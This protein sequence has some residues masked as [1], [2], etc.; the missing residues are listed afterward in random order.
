MKRLRI[1]L[2]EYKF[3][4]YTNPLFWVFVFIILIFS[5]VYTIIK[6]I[7][8]KIGF[9]DWWFVWFKLKTANEKAKQIILENYERRKKKKMPYFKRKAW[10]KAVKFIEDEH[11][12]TSNI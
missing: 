4:A 12:K 3:W 5:G 11:S 9:N 8:D 6:K 10:E 1:D 7:G 2:S